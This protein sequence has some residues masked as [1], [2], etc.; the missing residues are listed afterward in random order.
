MKYNKMVE[1]RFIERPNRFIAMV[2]VNGVIEKCHV[3]NTGRCRELLVPDA[4][5]FLEES[6]NPDRKTSINTD[7]EVKAYQYCKML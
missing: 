4:R 3:K 1:G 7:T 5:V 2:D 6:G